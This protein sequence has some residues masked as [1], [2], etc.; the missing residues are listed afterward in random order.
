MRRASKIDAVQPEFVVALMGLGCSVDSLAR[1]GDG[2]GDLLVGFGGNEGE[3]GIWVVAEVKSH[4]AGT[5]AGDPTE[6][7]LAWKKKAR[8]PVVLLRSLEDCGRVVE[9]MRARLRRTE[10]L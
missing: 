3:G 5:V 1:L 7:Q 9:M 8:G 6:K 4:K 10:I 2:R